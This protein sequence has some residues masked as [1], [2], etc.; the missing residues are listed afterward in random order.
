MNFDNNMDLKHTL[1][2]GQFPAKGYGEIDNIYYKYYIIDTER[3][4]VITFS[5]AADLTPKRMV[6]NK[7]YSPWGFDFISK[8]NY[9]VISFSCIDSISWYRSQ[10]FA[11]YLIE[12]QAFLRPFKLKL[13]YG[14]S[15]GGYGV[16]AY[17]NILGLDK[18]LLLNPISTLNADLAPWE[19]RF[20]SA[21]ELDWHSLFY[22][23]SDTNCEGYIVYDP[24]FSLDRKHASRYN[25]LQHLKLPGV[26]HRIPAHLQ[27]LGILKQLFDDF[28]T[29]QLDVKWFIQQ[30]RNRK[31][32]SGY[33]SWLLSSEN[34]R[35]TPKR[36]KLIKRH[37]KAFLAWRDLDSNAENEYINTLRDAAILLEGIDIGISFKLMR[38]AYE[39]RPNSDFLRRKLDKYRKIIRKNKNKVKKE[40]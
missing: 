40:F 29:D 3:T 24:L 20:H 6:N 14:G 28:T 8:R 30:A 37:Q 36:A 39:L 9:S 34:R 10:L 1:A 2:H 21:K 7:K 13:G 31:L 22:D 25:N 18:I 38:K 17:S 15:M 32:Y 19:T 23:G 4:L 26:G 11:K 16:S 35:L 12:I 33:Y 27:K 5:N